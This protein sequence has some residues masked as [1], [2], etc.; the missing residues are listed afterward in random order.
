MSVAEQ[1]LISGTRWPLLI[2]TTSDLRSSFNLHYDFSH[3]DVRSTD[4]RMQMN[5][6]HYA[7]YEPNRMNMLHKPAELNLRPRLTKKCLVT[8]GASAKQSE[9]KSK[10]K[11]ENASHT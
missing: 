11:K 7:G 1:R 2:T 3:S 6:G 8:L 4:L 9:D 10:K 5:V